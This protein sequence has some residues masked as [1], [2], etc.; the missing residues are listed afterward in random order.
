MK[1]KSVPT[2]LIGASLALVP[3]AMLAQ[4]QPAHS[5][6]SYVL[7]SA[8]AQDKTEAGVKGR[9]P[10]GYR[11][12]N[13]PETNNFSAMDK[14]FLKEAAMGNMAEIKLG[15]LAAEKGGTQAVKDF[16]NTMVQDHTQLNDMMKPF[17]EKAGVQMSDTLSP[18]DQALC[19]RLNGLSGQQFDSEYTTMMVKDHTKDNAEFRKEMSS[20]KNEDLRDAVKQG[21]QVIMRH[22]AMSHKLASSHDKSDQAGQSGEFGK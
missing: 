6:A 8:L 17:L 11:D 14:R 10:V 3:A 4:F 15:H 5:S 22:L 9:N 2:L 20:T 1:M 19:D 21:D 18:K 7:S 16:G 13:A 12:H